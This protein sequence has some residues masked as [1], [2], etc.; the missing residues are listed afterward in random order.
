[1][2]LPKRMAFFVSD[3]TGITAE[4]LG[5]SLL[6]Q[7]ESLNIEK[8]AVR[9]VDTPERA[10]ALRDRI[11]RHFREDG[12]KPLVFSTLIAEETRAI[13]KQANGHFIDFFEV[14]IGPLEQELGVKSSLTAGRSHGLT[15]MVEYSRRIDAVNFTLNHD[16]GSTTAHLAE[17]DI[18]LVGIS[19][20][21]K[22]PTCLY[23]SLHYGI[24]AANFP[25]TEDDLEDMKLP[26]SLRPYQD[27]LFGL[28]TDP[29]R[30]AQIRHERMPNSKYSSLEQCDYET[31]QAEALFRK[32]GV[33]YLRTTMKSIE[34]IATTIIDMAGLEKRKVRPHRPQA[35]V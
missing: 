2:S 17:A 28:T 33:P 4:T 23:L 35:H 10:K 8:Q 6:T 29:M 22:T 26:N 18:I 30:L 11:D 24:R 12:L 31:R 14:F 19:R 1:M 21:G 20:T 5:H 13:V 3:R 32:L 27:K 34:E 7:F 16:D 9:F 15:D 25:L